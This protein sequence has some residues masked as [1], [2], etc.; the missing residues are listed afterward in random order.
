M[1]IKKSVNFHEAESTLSRK[2]HLDLIMETLNDENLDIQLYRHTE[3]KTMILD[4][5]LEK[6]GLSSRDITNKSNYFDLLY[7][8]LYCVQFGHQS[9]IYFNILG[10]SHKFTD[11]TIDVIVYLAF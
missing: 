11:K 7:E 6:D 1:K 9:Q 8:K 4:L 3:S 5:F 2:N 10:A